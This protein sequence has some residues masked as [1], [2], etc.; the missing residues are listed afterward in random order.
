[1]DRNRIL[2]KNTVLLGIGQFIPKVL[3]IIIL[4][5]LTGYLSTEEYGVYDLILSVASLALPLMT[6]LIQQGAFRFLIADNNK[7]QEIVS[8]AFG[9]LILLATIWTV[10]LFVI[11]TINIYDPI[12][13]IEIFSCI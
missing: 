5:I 12:L 4:P 6:L 10:V 11:I 9:F 8:S 13:L 1:M 2:A 7:K 3:A